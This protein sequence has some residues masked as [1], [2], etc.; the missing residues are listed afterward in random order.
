MEERKPLSRWLPPALALLLLAGSLVPLLLLAPSARAAL[1]DFVYGGPVHFSLA[2]GGGLWSVVTAVWENVA[3]TYQDWQGTFSSVVLFSLEPGAFA[4]ELYGLTTPVMLCAVLC[5]VF[6][7]LR[8]V[9]G[10]DRRGRLILGAVVGFLSVQYLPDPGQGLFWWNGAAHYLA[11]W[12]FGVMAVVWL[13]KL[14]RAPERRF[15]PRTAAGCLMA[16]W[17]GGGNF[18]TALVLPVVCSLTVLW[19]LWRRRPRRAVAAGCLMAFFALAGLA[20]SVAAPGNAVRQAG[21]A[22]MPP[23]AAVGQSFVYAARTLAGMVSWPVAGAL[24]L[25]VGV[26]L[27]TWDRAV[28]AA[29]RLHPLGVAAASFCCF[30]ALYT[31]PLYAMGGVRALEG[32]LEDLFWVAAVL[33]VFGNALYAAAW[34]VG[35]WELP[36]KLPQWFAGVGAGVFLLALCL[37][38]SQ[39]NAAA[40]WRDLHSPARTTYL[41]EREGR[42]ALE[43]DLTTSVPRSVPL[44]D[45]PESFFQT[46][47]VTWRSDLLVDGAPIPMETYHGSGGEV[48]YVELAH[49][50]EVLDR[51]GALSAGDCPRVFLVRGGEYVSLRWVCDALGYQIGYD[52]PTDTIFITTR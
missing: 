44:T 42:A 25:C 46:R 32:R 48:T 11:F 38:F 22:P 5:P 14:I 12:C 10:L 31:P 27:R 50:L 3:Y 34:S 35:R 43:G 41:A 51:P 19:C 15:W 17:V 45:V 40:A 49:V 16:L 33:L 29:P 23:L 20:V 37:S 52:G 24:L 36:K 18:C 26:F 2:A 28:A 1:D 21:F 39:T 6:L 8:Q 9:P 30:A 4:P 13:L 47:L 7:V